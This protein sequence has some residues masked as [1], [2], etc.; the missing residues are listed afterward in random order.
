MLHSPPFAYLPF[1]IHQKM[2]QYISLFTEQKNNIDAHSADVLN[3]QRT[4]A[5][6]HF[7]AVGFPSRKVERYKYTDIEAL[8]APDYGLNLQRLNIPVNPFDV[9]QCDVPNLST[10][11]YFV[12]NDQF[13]THTMPKVQ[14]PEG[15]VVDSLAHAAQTNAELVAHYYN[16]LAAKKDSI[17]SLNTMLA[18]DGVFVY[19]PRNVRV[20]KT[21]QVVNIMKSMVPLMANRRVLIVLED[22]AELNML[23]CDHADDD[24]TSFL[25]RLWRYISARMRTSTSTLWRRL[26]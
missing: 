22:G 15:V 11:L 4:E 23:F 26:M 1:I 20:E 14:L 3:A 2:Q 7:S 8:F 5:F 21:I 25:L 13:S 10:A 6:E 24:L 17:A 16:R 18:Q 9:F 19:V 12:I